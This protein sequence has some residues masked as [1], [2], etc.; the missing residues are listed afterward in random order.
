MSMVSSASTMN[1]ELGGVSA[2]TLSCFRRV[3][4]RS[5]HQRIR[6]ELQASAPDVATFASGGP[7]WT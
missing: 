6:S 7:S 5:R 2:E 1:L 4:N 3:P